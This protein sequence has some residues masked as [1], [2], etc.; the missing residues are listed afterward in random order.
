VVV[1]TL[2]LEDGTVVLSADDIKHFSSTPLSCLALDACLAL[3]PRVSQPRDHLP[4]D[5]SPHPAARPAIASD[6]LA[7]LA[8]DVS[9]FA[10]QQ[11]TSQIPTMRLALRVGV[12]TILGRQS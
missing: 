5:L 8:E 2:A 9:G 12:F 10:A 4:F 6:M 7:R 11:N 3:A 1:G